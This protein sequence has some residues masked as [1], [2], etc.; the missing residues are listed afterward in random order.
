[1]LPG[2]TPV[3]VF[4]VLV[5]ALLV[6]GP[7][8]L[9]ELARQVGAAMNVY[10]EFR[11]RVHTELNPHAIVESFLDGSEPKAPEAIQAQESTS[12]APAGAAETP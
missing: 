10:R 5:V 4:V 3:H 12:D 7:T 8:K 1:V 11:D 6:F 2:L 9:P